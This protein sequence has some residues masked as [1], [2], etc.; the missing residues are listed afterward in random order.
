MKIKEILTEGYADKIAHYHPNHNIDEI[1]SH[2]NP[3]AAYYKQL[4]KTEA[5][6]VSNGEIK[7]TTTCEPDDNRWSTETSNLRVQSAGARGLDQIK[8]SLKK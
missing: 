4:T 6:D 8:K 5:A 1:D 3:E 2:Y 7:V